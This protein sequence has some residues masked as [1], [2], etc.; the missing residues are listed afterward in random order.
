MIIIYFY[1]YHHWL[2]LLFTTSILH[3]YPL[4]SV[5]VV[6]P[7]TIVNFPTPISFFPHSTGWLG[8]LLI[9]FL[10][11][12]PSFSLPDYFL[13]W[14]PLSLLNSLVIPIPSPCWLVL[15][16]LR[17]SL[18]WF[19]SVHPTEYLSSCLPPP[20]QSLSHSLTIT[21]HRS[22]INPLH[23]CLAPPSF[24]GSGKF[25]LPYHVPFL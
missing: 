15:A 4:C 13:Y 14:I 16:S 9:F 11:T 8:S 12:A 25:P 17:G 18:D 23:P 6:I 5:V 20:L 24:F 2:S 7:I 1:Y 3:W 10:F 19:S 22:L 21:P